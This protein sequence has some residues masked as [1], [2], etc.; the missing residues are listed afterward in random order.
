MLGDGQQFDMGVAHFFDVRD[1]PIRELKVTQI[2]VILFG[3]SRPRPQVNLINTHR[4]LRPVPRFSFRDPGV[5]TPFEA[6]E[7]KDKGSRLHSML[8]KERE[9]VAFQ[10]NIAETVAD[11]VFV[12]G[13][14]TDPWNEYFP[15]ACFNASS[16]RIG[17][18]IPAVKIP[19]YADPL[20]IRRPNGKA[21]ARMSIDLPQVSSELFVD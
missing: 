1:Q 7:I 20:S 13:V 12:V 2:S 10:H 19:H 17:P 18:A 14:F 15:D 6:I 21:H 8:C 3:N 4:L 11:L 5:I 16:H 9:G